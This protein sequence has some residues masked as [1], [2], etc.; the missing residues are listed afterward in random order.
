M[1][2]I[3][4]NPMFMFIMGVVVTVSIGIG[5]YAINASE[6]S[7]GNT[8]VDDT[9]DDLYD[10]AGSLGTF[11]KKVCT[12]T[13]QGSYGNA[14]EVGS[15]YDC[16]VGPNIHKNFY[17]LA[18]NGDKVDLIMQHNITEG[19]SPTTMTFNNAMKYVKNNNLKAGMV[20]CFRC[21]FTKGT[22]YSKC[23]RKR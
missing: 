1:K 20:K 18:V 7:Y 10:K 4:K 3:F 22:R 2:K 15:L 17:I 21:R 8:T 13:S 9:L 12:Y 23:S 19:A 6:I 14:G 5:V 11:T 16:E